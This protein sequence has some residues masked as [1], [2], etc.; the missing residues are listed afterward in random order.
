M[1]WEF[2]NLLLLFFFLNVRT[3]AVAATTAVADDDVYFS[4]STKI[5]LFALY[6][7]T[8][9]P[10]YSTVCQLEHLRC[11]NEYFITHKCKKTA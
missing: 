6:T 9:I 5:K 8:Q 3:K 10:D 7:E 11:L 1:R 2:S 4:L